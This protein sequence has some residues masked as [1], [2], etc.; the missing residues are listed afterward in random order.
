MK[1]ILDFVSRTRLLF[2]VGVLLVA[3]TGVATATNEPGTILYSGRAIV[4]DTKAG[5][6]TSKTRVVLADTGEIDNTGATRETTVVDF[7]NPPPIEV[8]SQTAHAIAG[9]ANGVS[10]ANAVVER[11]NLKVGNLTLFAEAINGFAMAECRLQSGTVHPAG[12]SHVTNLVINGRTIVRDMNKPNTSLAIPGVA[13][14]YF[15]HQTRPDVNTI[16]V[17]AIRVVV[18]GVPGVATVT[19]DI[20]HA[21][22]GIRTCAKL[23]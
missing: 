20:G 2:L 16:H 8:R 11:L 10:S 17:N 15:N 23:A 5:I 6:L 21:E 3:G 19:I 1:R 7:E 4:L 13:T 9:G 14:I 12:S 18:P 22:A